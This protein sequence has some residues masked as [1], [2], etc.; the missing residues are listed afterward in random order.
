MHLESQCTGHR[1]L[2]LQ[3]P[4]AECDF[5]TPTT[6]SDLAVSLRAAVGGGNVVFGNDFFSAFVPGRKLSFRC[7]LLRYLAVLEERVVSVEQLLLED[8]RVLLL[9]QVSCSAS[10]C[11]RPDGFFED[12]LRASLRSLYHVERATVMDAV[13]KDANP[14]LHG[15]FYGTLCT[16]ALLSVVVV[17][18]W[19]GGSLDIDS[20]WFFP[21]PCA[22]GS[23]SRQ[24]LY[25]L[26]AIR[27][28]FLPN[29]DSLCYL[30]VFHP[31][32]L[33]RRFGHLYC[34]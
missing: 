3:E 9:M 18:V 20:G 33:S 21:T 10:G 23:S 31:D 27:F 34:S 6:P 4:S 5:R 16:R 14:S 26:D 11:V 13:W 25:T 12:D 29:P 1:Q 22:N 28:G 8:E 30:L 32:G 7:E 19:G 17:G 15:L 2:R 24:F